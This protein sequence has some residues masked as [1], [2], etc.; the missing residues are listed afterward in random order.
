MAYS[1]LAL[2]SIHA[3]HDVNAICLKGV[4]N[5]ALQHVKGNCVL[6]PD[7]KNGELSLLSF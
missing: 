2:H 3:S 7:C 6:Y 5:G 1:S 4:E